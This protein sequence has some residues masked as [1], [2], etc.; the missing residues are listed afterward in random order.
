MRNVRDLR[1]GAVPVLD[2][3]LAEPGT[4]RAPL[5]DRG[6]DDERAVEPVLN[7]V[8]VDVADQGRSQGGRVRLRLP[9]SAT[10]P[11]G[12]APRPRRF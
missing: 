2:R 3:D 8:L 4:E 12:V 10:P 1:N 6:L 7:P 11:G 5:I 9:H